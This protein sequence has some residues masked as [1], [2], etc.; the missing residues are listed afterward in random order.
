MDP[1]PELW[2]KKAYTREEKK[3][4]RR[5][6]KQQIADAIAQKKEMEQSIKQMEQSIKQILNG[7][8]VKVAQS[9]LRFTGTQESLEEAI[10]EVEKAARMLK[11]A[12]AYFVLC[13]KKVFDLSGKKK[14]TQDFKIL[15]EQEFEEAKALASANPAAFLAKYLSA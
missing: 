2:Q 11:S 5:F 12:E 1:K 14:E 6:L 10:A 9:A 13:Q 7:L 3:Q 15:A 8:Y 4:H